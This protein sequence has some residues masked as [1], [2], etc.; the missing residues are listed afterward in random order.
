MKTIQDEIILFKQLLDMLEKQLGNNTEVVLLDLTK[1]YGS[2]IV[3]IRNG[4]ITGR[5]IGGTGSNMGLE[6]LA[7]TVKNG[8][9]YNYITKSKD[10]KILRSSTLYIRDD[11]ENVIGCLCINTDITE[12]VK[13][14]AFLKEFNQ[15]NFDSGELESPEIFAQDVNQVLEFLIQE[16][17]KL[18]GKPA[19]VM[20]KNEKIQFLKYLNDK[21][22]FLITKS[23]EKIQEIMGIS[24]YTMYNYLDMIKK[25]DLEE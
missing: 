6:V 20:S 14:E 8:N 25:G 9:R 12:S 16:G 18:V 15:Y 19:A 21:G 7:G 3:D 23:G 5:K 10:N 11:E 13:F 17:Q 1:E 24:K 4:H 2:M 22:A